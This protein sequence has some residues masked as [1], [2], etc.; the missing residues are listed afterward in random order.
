MLEYRTPKLPEVMPG[1]LPLASYNASDA[2]MLYTGQARQRGG[3]G[4][5]RRRAN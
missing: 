5:A 2:P 4:G 1:S 3:E